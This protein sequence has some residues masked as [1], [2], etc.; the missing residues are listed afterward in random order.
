[1]DLGVDTISNR[2]LRKE[3]REQCG[4]ESKYNALDL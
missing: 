3:G 4:S 2:K 1:M